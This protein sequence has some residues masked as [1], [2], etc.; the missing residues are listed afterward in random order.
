M[1][2]ESDSAFSEH[3]SD[4]NLI[5]RVREHGDKKALEMIYKR[6]YKG[7]HG[8]ARAFIREFQVAEDIIQNVFLKIWENKETWNPDGKLR[9]Y[10]F[11]AVRNESLNYKR[12]SRIVKDSAIE[13]SRIYEERRDFDVDEDQS[14]IKLEI[15]KGI[16]NLPPRCREI[17]LLNRKSGLTYTEI[18]LYLDIS[19]NTVDTQMGRALETLRIFLSEHLSIILV[20]SAH[21]IF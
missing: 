11:T 13:L 10:L 15:E 12:H 8:F 21:T 2:G 16:N 18:A 5:R 7:L 20:I 3:R 14:D 19:I 9:H 17:F 1:F 6:Y 4:E